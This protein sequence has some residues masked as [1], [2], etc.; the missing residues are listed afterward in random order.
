MAKAVF[1]WQVTSESTATHKFEVRAVKLGD[2]YEQ[3]QQKFLRPKLQTWDVKIVG[4]RVLIDEIKAF[5]DARRGVES[6]YWQPIGREKLLVK[7]SE[8]T[9]TPKGGQVYELSCKFEEVMA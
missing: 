5:F 6:F 1:K 7:V 9:E 3:R 8:Y 2:C 4:F